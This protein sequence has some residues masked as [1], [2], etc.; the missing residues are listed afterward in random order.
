[1]TLALAPHVSTADTGTGMALL[2]ERTGRYWALNATAALM[3]RTLLEEQSVERTVSVLQTR[4][5]VAAERVHVDTE[6]LLRSL[7]EARLV[8]TS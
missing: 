8:T 4:Y 1:M 7:C 5:P 3:V 2:D 6:V